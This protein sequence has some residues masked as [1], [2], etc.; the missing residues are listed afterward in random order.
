MWPGIEGLHLGRHRQSPQPLHL[1]RAIRFCVNILLRSASL[2]GSGD[3]DGTMYGL[4]CLAPLALGESV[5]MQ[6]GSVVHCY[7][8]RMMRVDALRVCR[9]YREASKELALLLRGEGLPLDVVDPAVRERERVAAEGGGGSGGDGRETETETTALQKIVENVVKS[10]PGRAKGGAGDGAGG[11]ADGEK[12]SPSKVNTARSSKGSPGSTKGG[13][14]GRTGTDRSG[15]GGGEGQVSGP[16]DG[17]TSDFLEYEYQEADPYELAEDSSSSITSSEPPLPLLCND[18]HLLHADNVQAVQWILNVDQ[19]RSKKRIRLLVGRAM[20]RRLNLIRVEMLID[21]ASIQPSSKSTSITFLS[22]MQGGE[23][24]T[25]ETD[26]MLHT[27]SQGGN[28]L[29]FFFFYFFFEHTILLT[30]VF[31]RLDLLLLF[32]V[33]LFVSLFVS[34]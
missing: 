12:S 17:E 20:I 33:C 29:F 34:S 10:R 9:R 3:G 7:E 31:S 16:Y 4:A 27:V 8:I 32:V 5:A 13:E 24:I 23:E 15:A 19:I 14:T 25:M 6:C 11:G 21:L 22:D 18:V 1:L 30:H 2:I 28:F 26:T